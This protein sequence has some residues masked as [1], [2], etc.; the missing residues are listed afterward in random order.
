MFQFHKC[1]F[2]FMGTKALTCGRIAWKHLREVFR[3]QLYFAG[4]F[5][6]AQVKRMLSLFM[7]EV[8]WYALGM[9]S[10]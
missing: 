1:F 2:H 4:K 9:V 6:V 8:M 7:H 5:N 3:F 10:F